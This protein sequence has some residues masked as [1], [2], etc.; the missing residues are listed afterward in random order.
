MER[1]NKMIW[2]V[3]ALSM[4]QAGQSN[5]S[6][7]LEGT[8]VN[9]VKIDANERRRMGFL[10]VPPRPSN[11]EYATLRIPTVSAKSCIVKPETPNKGNND[12]RA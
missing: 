9:D 3:F 6:C 11:A 12:Y 5:V 1:D 10:F 4:G 2:E 8:P 7:F